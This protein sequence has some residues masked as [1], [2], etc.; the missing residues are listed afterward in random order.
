M[1]STAPLTKEDHASTPRAVALTSLSILGLTSPPASAGEIVCDRSIAIRGSSFDPSL[2]A[3]V[4][5]DDLHLCWHNSDGFGHTATANSGVFDT[6]VIAG[7]GAADA[8]L[9]G[10]GAYLYHC[11]IHPFM[12]ATFNVRPG[13][14]DGAI[15]PGGSFELRVGDHGTLTPAPTWDVPAAPQHRRMGHDPD[16]H[17]AGELP[18]RPPADG[19]VPLPGADTHLSNVTGWS[20]ARITCR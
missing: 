13:V 17:L 1:P 8:Q 18:D 9:F 5:Q 15:A 4:V 14:S 6:G 20:P 16:R 11:E 7:D 12:T 3:T 2:A 19:D 10:S